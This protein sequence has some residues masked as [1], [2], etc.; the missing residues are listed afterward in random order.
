MSRETRVWRGIGYSLENDVR[1][2]SSRDSLRAISLTFLRLWGE[3]GWTSIALSH[4]CAPRPSHLPGVC[5]SRCSPVSSV[6][7]SPYM[8]V[9]H[10]FSPLSVCPALRIHNHT[11]LPSSH[12]SSYVY[13]NDSAYTNISATVG[14]D[15]SLSLKYMSAF[16]IVTHC[17]LWC[18]YQHTAH[19]GWS[20]CVTPLCSFWDGLSMQKEPCE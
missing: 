5:V 15:H 10:Y 8:C 13:T 9:I 12:N 2:I 19:Y 16:V 1:S 18:V 14:E 3:M 17:P 11:V 20:E 6:F 7:V 4:T